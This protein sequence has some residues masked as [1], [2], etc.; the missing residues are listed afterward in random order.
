MN[1]VSVGVP[2]SVARAWNRGHPTVG[3]P[4]RT[5]PSVSG[6]RAFRQEGSASPGT[7]TLASHLCNDTVNGCSVAEDAFVRVRGGLTTDTF[8][9]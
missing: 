2:G 3:T 8:C 9:L 6:H 4:G 5:H 7:F 1:A